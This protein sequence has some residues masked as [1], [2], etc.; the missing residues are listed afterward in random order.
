MKSIVLIL[1]ALLTFASWVEAKTVVTYPEENETCTLGKEY[2]GNNGTI[3][4]PG[5]DKD[6][7]PNLNCLFKILLP[8]G[9]LV[10]FS[11][12]RFGFEHYENLGNGNECDGNYDWLKF[13]NG[14]YSAYCV[15]NE[16]K[17]TAFC[18]GGVKALN[19]EFTSET[20]EIT[21]WMYSDDTTS[22]KGFKLNWTAVGV[23]PITTPKPTCGCNEIGTETTD[24]EKVTGKCTCNPGYDGDKCDDCT[25]DYW[26]SSALTG[27]CKKCDDCD[28]EENQTESCN[29]SNGKC[30]C[31]PK[32]ACGC[33]EI[34]TETTDCEKETGQCTCN[35]GYDGDNCDDC[36]K[37]YWISSA[38][39]GECKKCDDCN[40]EE[41]QTESCNTS[42]GKAP[43]SESC[44]CCSQC[45]P[46]PACGCNE[47]GTE[48]TN[49]EK[50][51]GK[52]T[53]KAG[54]D[55]PKC[56]GCKEDYWISSA[57][58]GECKK[59]ETCDEKCKENQTG[60]CDKS[61]GKCKCSSAATFAFDKTIV[62][63]TALLIFLSHQNWKQEIDIKICH[64][65]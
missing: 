65:N 34:G 39:T 30:V 11:F 25:K 32:P 29:K 33:N 50:K 22:G 27:E 59:C 53:C 43:V 40:C 63:F 61:N 1:S 6:Y 47:I 2:S 7:D 21:L 64:T 35:P 41:N 58:I 51:T 37:D 14:N 57:L 24:C 26:T 15:E 44:V 49:C 60:S 54:Y 23:G 56:D 18:M 19:K 5:E 45:T 38:L 20:N 4:F 62:L 9:F 8:K 12:S 52:C 28:C 48:K 55:G 17:T 42:N 10:Q 31:T 16:N 13:I 36:T 46:K 3:D